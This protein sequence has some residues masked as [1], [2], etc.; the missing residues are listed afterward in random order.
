MG[1]SK[2]IKLFRIYQATINEHDIVLSSRATKVALTTKIEAENYCKY[3]NNKNNFGTSKTRFYFEEENLTVFKK[4]HD[5][6]GNIDEDAI[7]FS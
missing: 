7:L 6:A 5:L 3:L 1:K 4:F 2:E